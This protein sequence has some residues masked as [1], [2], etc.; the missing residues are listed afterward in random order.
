MFACLHD[1]GR[2][3]NN[4]G[5]LGGGNDTTNVEPGAGGFQSISKG[6]EDSSREN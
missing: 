2:G 1:V 6:D 4:L 3:Y 5:S